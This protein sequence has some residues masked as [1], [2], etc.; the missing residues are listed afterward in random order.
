MK[1]TKPAC[2][3]SPAFLSEIPRR[4][5]NQTPLT[6]RSPE[7][8]VR[9]QRRVRPCPR[10]PAL[11]LGDVGVGDTWPGLALGV[12]S[13]EGCWGAGLPQPDSSAEPGPAARGGMGLA[14]LPRLRGCTVTLRPNP[15]G[16]GNLFPWGRA[17]QAPGGFSGCF[18]TPF[19]F[20]VLALR[21]P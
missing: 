3:L 11:P 1:R 21:F 19:A 16:K 2:F 13:C 12:R 4:N 14:L 15:L 8:A 17:K 18:S 7:A 6:P 20:W 9:A 10:G 5:P